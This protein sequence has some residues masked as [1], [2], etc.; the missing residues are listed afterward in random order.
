MGNK[1]W[2]VYDG[3]AQGDNYIL[4]VVG[5]TGPGEKRSDNEEWD[6]PLVTSIDGEPVILNHRAHL[7]HEPSDV[8]QLELV[9][10]EYREKF[11]EW[12][13]RQ[14]EE[15]EQVD[16]EEPFELDDEEHVALGLAIRSRV[17]QLTD[18]RDRAVVMQG[19]VKVA[20]ACTA[21]IAALTRIYNRLDL[22][23]RLWDF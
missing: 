10:D 11:A 23:P 8:E 3:V 20:N 15:P 17:E 12:Q 7:D 9:P 14:D 13:A 22:S 5:P 18:V 19:S 2:H 4:V 21:Q 16:E 6:S 1:T